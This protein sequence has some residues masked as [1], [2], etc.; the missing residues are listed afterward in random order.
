MQ[1]EALLSGSTSFRPHQQKENAPNRGRFLFVRAD[2]KARTLRR[3]VSLKIRKNNIA[4][5]KNTVLAFGKW[6]CLA[7][8]AF[9]RRAKRSR[10]AKW[11]KCPFVG[12]NGIGL[13]PCRL[14]GF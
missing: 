12:A 6:R 4:A 11:F 3:V 9:F 1:G 13:S 14:E 7:A 2:A 8:K 5:E 10:L